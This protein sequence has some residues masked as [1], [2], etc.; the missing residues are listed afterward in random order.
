MSSS[1]HSSAPASPSETSTGRRTTVLAA[2]P[3]SAFRTVDLVTAA[4]V[5][6]A[7]G[8][9]F[10]AWSLV[11]AATS[12]PVGALVAPLTSILAGP[13]LLA[14][15]VAGLLVR[16]P[17]AALMAEVVAASVSALIGSE[18]GW[19]TVVSGVLQGLGVE[20][21]LALFAWRRFGPAVAMLA[22][23]L[24]ATLEVVGYE[25][26]TFYAGFDLRFKLVYLAFFVLSGAVAAGLGGWAI[27]RALARLGAVN[28]MPPG[29]EELERS[30]R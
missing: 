15:V 20:I 11:Y 24:A 26:W 23:S 2:R 14:G 25:W 7:F 19:T 10:W 21:A 17:G 27:V 1:A 5:G 9:V 28:A 8:V 16:R 22:G 6:V 12:G 13:W 29:Q 3:L 30:L 18:W 4:M